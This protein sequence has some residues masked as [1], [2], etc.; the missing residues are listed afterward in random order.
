[1]KKKYFFITG[2]GTNVGKTVISAI[3]VEALKADY[4]KPIQAGDLSFSDTIFVKSLISNSVSHFHKE[5]YALHLAAS[6]HY[7]AQEENIEIRVSDFSIPATENHLIIEG[8]GGVLVPLNEQELMIDL[9]VKLDAEII[10]VSENYLGSI[11]HTLL[12]VE[13]LRHRGLT[14]RGIIFNGKHTP[15]TEKFILSY[16]QLPC[17]LRV[18][19]EEEANPVMIRRY[20]EIIRENNF[21]GTNFD[22]T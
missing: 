10:L 20:A 7:A 15:S 18:E 11:N 6:P 12:S 4:W 9:M 14:I 2:I 8:A 21:L 5:V 1:M 3:L 19:Q 16:T 22:R 13:A 17:L